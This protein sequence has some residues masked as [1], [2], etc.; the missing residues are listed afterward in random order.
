M[1]HNENTNSHGPGGV[2]KDDDPKGVSKDKPLK[3]NKL[4]VVV[5]PRN[6]EVTVTPE[7]ENYNNK[8]NDDTVTVTK[9]TTIPSLQQKR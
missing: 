3:G 9:A 5:A 8:C 6:K 2:P 1:T 7:H 4:K